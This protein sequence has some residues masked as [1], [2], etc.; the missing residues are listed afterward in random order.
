MILV[1]TSVWVEHLRR[2]QSHA[3]LEFRDLAAT[4]PAGIATCEPIAMELLAGPTDPF[5]VRRLE[6]QLGTLEDLSVDSAQDFRAAGTLARA[7]RRS[8]RTVRSLTDCL[9]AAIALRHGAD[10]WHCDEDYVR[11]A[12]VTDLRQRDLRER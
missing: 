9:V 10:V 11:I 5:T 6:D 3:H 8:G 1:D 4:D 7:V 12:D 2:T